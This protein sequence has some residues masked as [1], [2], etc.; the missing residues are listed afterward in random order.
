MMEAWL[1]FGVFDFQNLIGLIG[2]ELSLVFAD[3]KSA[4]GCKIIPVERFVFVEAKRYLNT[5]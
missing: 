5:T 3:S 1:L 2:S 4:A